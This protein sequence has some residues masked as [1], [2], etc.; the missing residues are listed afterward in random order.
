MLGNREKGVVFVIS[1]PAG[2]GKTTLTQM[3]CEE[4]KGKIFESVSC[5]TRKKRAGEQDGVHYH[6]IAEEEFQKKANAGE[7]LEHVHVFDHSYGTLKTEIHAKTQNGTHVILVIDTQGAMRLKNIIDAVY[8]F[9]APPSIQE[10]EKRL[11][12][13]QTDSEEMIKKRLLWAEKE[14]TYADQYDYFIVNENL[15]LAYQV[16]KS[17]VVAEEHR[18][19]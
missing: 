3:L 11:K 15:Q 4:F 5:T 8:I 17:I 19:R 13:R 18:N 16:L 10:L 9:I 6:F 14:I 2:T 7:F 12:L 1:A